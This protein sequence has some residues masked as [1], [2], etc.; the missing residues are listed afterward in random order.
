MLADK[1]KVTVMSLLILAVILLT[2]IAFQL[3]S[4]SKQGGNQRYVM[5]NAGSVV[6]DTR[7]GNA[8]KIYGQQF[9]KVE[10]K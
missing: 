3:N 8:Y 4:V 1:F 10:M 5:N 9:D 2:I 7:T 6:L